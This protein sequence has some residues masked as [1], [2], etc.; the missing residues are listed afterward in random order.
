[1]RFTKTVGGAIALVLVLALAAS[2]ASAEEFHVEGTTGPFTIRG[3]QI[4]EENHVFTLEG[5]LTIK[6]RKATFE[7][8]APEKTF[9]EPKLVPVY[10]ECTIFGLSAP[11]AG[12]GCEFKFGAPSSP[13]M[14]GFSIT[15]PAGKSVKLTA[16]T[17]EVRFPAQGALLGVRYRNLVTTPKEVEIETA[18]TGIKYEKTKDGFLCPLSGTGTKEDGALSG[19]TITKGFEGETQRNIY[20]E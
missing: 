16:G 9:T 4:A 6:C 17:C 14:S 7:G 18:V 3:S 13:S 19:M 2:A 1:M 10:S 8:S 11:V 20:V 5:G 12:E 15:C